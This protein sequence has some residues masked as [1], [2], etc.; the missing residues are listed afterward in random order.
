M[1]TCSTS[2]VR[3]DSTTRSTRGSDTV[4]ARNSAGGSGQWAGSPMMSSV[5][6]AIAAS[7][8]C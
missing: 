2:A 6:S 7:S 1:R 8:V 3:P 5:P 4:N